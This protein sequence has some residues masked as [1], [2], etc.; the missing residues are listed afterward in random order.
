[1]TTTPT[2]DGGSVEVNDADV[3]ALAALIV[4]EG[5]DEDGVDDVVYDCCDASA[6]WRFNNDEEIAALDVDTALDVAGGEASATA[7]SVNNG[8]AVAQAAFLIAELGA[9]GARS[10]LENLVHS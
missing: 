2:S 6:A 5:Y 4:A 9:D 1:M 7:S 3:G 8:G 10:T